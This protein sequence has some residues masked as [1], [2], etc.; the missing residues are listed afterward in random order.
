LCF[1][2]L[3]GQYGFRGNVINFPQDIAAF[4]RSLPRRVEDLP[5]IIVR[6][7]GQQPEE[8]DDFKVKVDNIRTWLQHL[9]GN[10]VLS[11]D[12]DIDQ[13]ELNSLPENG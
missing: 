1:N 12:Y 10:G 7:R 6:R 11:G 8:Y 5:I 3:G 9:V 13:D 2:P 4:A